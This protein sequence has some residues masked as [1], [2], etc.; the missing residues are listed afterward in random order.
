MIEVDDDTDDTDVTSDRDARSRRTRPVLA[1][2]LL[3]LCVLAALLLAGLLFLRPALGAVSSDPVPG[4]DQ[5]EQDRIAV[6]Q[7]TER[8]TE[9]WNTFQPDDVEGYVDRVSALLTT[10]FKAKFTNASGD[11]AR[12]IAAQKLASQG[13]VLV[14]D[15]GIPLVGI[16]SIDPDSAQTLVV[17]DASRVAS[18]QKVLRHWRW[19]VFLVKVGGQWLVDDFKEV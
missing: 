5:A 9:T 4:G 6:L 8:F 7:A 12:A 15:D 10:A 3:I 1:T 13:E 2:V 19:Q 18:G 11:L 16:A 14:D 17:S